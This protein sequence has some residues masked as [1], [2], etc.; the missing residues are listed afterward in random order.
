V[1]N[2]LQFDNTVVAVVVVV[3]VV[4]RRCKWWSEGQILPDKVFEL[5]SYLYKKNSQTTSAQMMIRIIFDDDEIDAIRRLKE[6]G[7]KVRI[8]D[9]WIEYWHVRKEANM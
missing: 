6:L 9:D 4:K 1:E 2:E 7:Q 5:A 3:V 8:Q